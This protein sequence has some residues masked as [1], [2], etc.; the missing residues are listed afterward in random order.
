MMNNQP[1]LNVEQVSQA[2]GFTSA[3]TFTRNFRAKYGMTPTT[4]RQTIFRE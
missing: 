3:D 4:Y 2:S 1:D